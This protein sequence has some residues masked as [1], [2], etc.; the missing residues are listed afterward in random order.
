MSLSKSFSI[1]G[2]RRKIDTL[3]VVFIVATTIPPGSGRSNQ[4]ALFVAVFGRVGHCS[5]RLSARR[6]CITAISGSIDTKDQV[7]IMEGG[8]EAF[9][10][11]K[12][13]Y[14]VWNTA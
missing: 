5:T 7:K 4:T 9:E 3:V 13:I 11:R 10:R 12:V 8:K 14:Q 6:P 1:P 2:F